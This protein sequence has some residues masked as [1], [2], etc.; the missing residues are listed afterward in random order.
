MAWI[1]TRWPRS[2]RYS[3]PGNVRELASLVERAMVTQSRPML[4]ISR[5]SSSAHPRSARRSSPP[6]RSIPALSAHIDTTWPVDLDDTLN[7]GL[8]E[9]QREHILRVLNATHWVI[10]GNSGAALRLGLKP[11]TLRHRMKK[12]G[13]CAPGSAYPERPAAANSAV[14]EHDVPVR[15]RDRAQDAGWA[16]Q[17]DNEA[18]AIVTGA[19]EQ[20]VAV[21]ERLAREIHL[22][23][24]P[25]DLPVTSKWMCGGR[26]N[27]PAGYPSGL[28]VFTR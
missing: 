11:A 25:L 5:N 12:L 1:R 6:R 19:R 7:T 9:V 27:P 10:E 2:M 26:S 15:Q 20:G 21:V 18:M 4:K 8:H 17:R 3:W 28:M 24:Q 22:R 16:L 13:I 23:D 14:L